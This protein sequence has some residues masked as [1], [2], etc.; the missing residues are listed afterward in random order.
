MD[1]GECFRVPAVP[2]EPFVPPTSERGLLECARALDDVGM[3]AAMFECVVQLTKVR[4]RVDIAILELLSGACKKMVGSH[5]TALRYVRTKHK[6]DVDVPRSCSADIKRI[7]D[8]TLGVLAD[9]PSKLPDIAEDPCAHVLMH[10]LMGD[11]HRYLCDI[12]TDEQIKLK[13]EGAY[14]EAAAL[15]EKHL[16]AAHPLRLGVALNRSILAYEIMKSPD[17]GVTIAKQAFD[18]AYEIMKSRDVED[19]K[20]KDAPPT[21]AATHADPHALS[22][23]DLQQSTAVLERLRENV[24]L[25]T[26]NEDGADDEPVEPTEKP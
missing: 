24:V 4:P 12:E 5:R 9:V 1:N 26:E 19:T 2:L 21:G 11:Y 18:L 23:V 3:G 16:P 17:E 8:D 22:E 7:C 10:T 13:A 6:A 15:A 25:W 20:S 14:R